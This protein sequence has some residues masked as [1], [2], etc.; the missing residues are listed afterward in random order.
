MKLDASIDYWNSF[1]Q[2]SVALTG[3]TRFQLEG[4]GQA[5]LYLD[6]VRAAVPDSDA[7]SLFETFNIE[8]LDAILQS[9]KLDAIARNIMKLWYIATWDALGENT[10]P[11]SPDATRIVSPEAYTEGLVW[12]AIGVNPSAAKPL[13][14]ASWSTSP[15]IRIV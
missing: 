8:G 4:T 6:T 11:S 3:F 10:E 1:L 9:E 15:V 5:Q 2:L 7:K 14:Y 12:P 13:G